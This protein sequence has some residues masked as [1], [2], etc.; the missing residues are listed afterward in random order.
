ML[1]SVLT[2]RAHEAASHRKIARELFTDN[3][4]Q[5]ISRDHQ[6]VVFLL[7][8]SFALSKSQYIDQ[9]KHHI[10]SNVHP[11]PLSAHRGWFGSGQFRLCNEYLQEQ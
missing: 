8:G 6:G 9:T 7:R 11:S 1:N 4:I 3:I 2:V 10:I 5:A